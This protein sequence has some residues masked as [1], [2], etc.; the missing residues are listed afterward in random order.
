MTITK[1]EYLAEC[2]KINVEEAK[3]KEANK[4]EVVADKGTGRGN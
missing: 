4:K 2:A 3:K 1:K